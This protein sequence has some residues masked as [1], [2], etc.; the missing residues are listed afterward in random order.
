MI[1][2]YDTV[3]C[4]NRAK[5]DYYWRSVAWVRRIN[6]DYFRWRIIAEIF[7]QR[8]ENLTRNEG[9]QPRSMRQIDETDRGEIYAQSRCHLPLSI[10]TKIFLLFPRDPS[11]VVLITLNA[12]VR[13]AWIPIGGLRTGDSLINKNHREIDDRHGSTAAHGFDVLIPATITD[14]QRR[15]RLD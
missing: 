13:R 8:L 15:N 3:R 7:M 1:N 4:I 11:T 10:R 6:Y 2:Q 9:R 14:W 12:Y 5:T